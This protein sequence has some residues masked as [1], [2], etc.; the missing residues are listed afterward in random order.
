MSLHLFN[1]FFQHFVLSVHVIFIWVHL[2]LR[3]LLSVVI[4]KQSYFLDFLYRLLI[5]ST[6]K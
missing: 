6:Q 1:L 4:V 3:I 5:S 2:T